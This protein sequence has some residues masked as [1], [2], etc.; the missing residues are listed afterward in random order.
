MEEGVSLSLPRKGFPVDNLLVVFVPF[1]REH[2]F[3]GGINLP[4]S[5]TEEGVSLSLPRNGFSVDI[6]LEVS[7]PFSREH[8]FSGGI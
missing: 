3:Y 5:L 6:H 2:G 4:D 1:S 7:F 8:G